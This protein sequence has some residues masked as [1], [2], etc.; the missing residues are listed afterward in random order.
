VD[1]FGKEM[2]QGDV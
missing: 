2:M 1:Q